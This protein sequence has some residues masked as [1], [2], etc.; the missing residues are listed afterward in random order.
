MLSVAVCTWN[1]AARLARTLEAMTRLEPPGAGGGDGGWELVVVDNGSTDGTAATIDGFA[2]R[3]PVRRVTEPRTGLSHARNA[4]VAAA[5]GAAIVWTDDDV[6]VEPG[7]LAAY[8]RALDRWPDADVFGGPI[9]PH[10]DAPPPAWLAAGLPQVRNAYA[11]LDLGPEPV[12]LGGARLPF[13]ANYA[14][15]T[16]A[17]RRV[18]YSPALGRVGAAL[19]SGEETA[20]V[21]AL[22]DAGAR[23]WWV[24]EARV[25]HLV[26][27]ERQSVRFLRAYYRG[28]GASLHHEPGFHAPTHG[29]RLLGRPRW[30]WRLAVEQQ[31]LYW[32]RR[33]SAPPE[34]WLRHLRLASSAWGT[35][36]ARPP[37]E[38]GRGA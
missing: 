29:P 12:P 22:L 16:A 35:L 21:R 4:A 7:W 38:D 15:R 13:G 37:R 24:P 32:L 23:G 5:R 11:L 6:L 18:A 14:I 3:L 8:A 30:V 36:L 2:G 1:R 17:Q 28:N 34:R 33:P 31:L 25:A 27:P 19:G 9:L 10:F 20:V 26:P